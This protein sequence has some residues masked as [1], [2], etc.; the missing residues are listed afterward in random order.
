LKAAIAITPIPVMGLLVAPV[1]GRL[2]NRIPPRVLAVPGLF[3][4]AGGLLWLSAIPAEPKYTHVVVA[5][6]LIGA[7]VGAMFPAV[8]IGSM[9]SIS[10]HE[11]GLGSGIVNMSRQVG[12]AIGVALLVAVF[13]GTIDN[14]VASARREVASLLRQ[15]GLSPAQSAEVRK[16]VLVNPS[17]PSSRQ[18]PTA[19]PETPIERRAQRIVDER[20][21]D[22]YGAAF[23]VAGLVTLLAL[24]FSLTM[25]KLPGQVER[26]DAPVGET[27]AASV[28]A[29][30]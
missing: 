8:S 27:A 20:V 5:L 26:E 13:T 6:A 11:L 24:P 18:R 3:S 30:A 4:M 1:V 22:S 29:P 19:A 10:G 21:R 7:G 2:S 12:F 16:R 14:N 15:S 23:R 25:R 28:E 9:G 17:D